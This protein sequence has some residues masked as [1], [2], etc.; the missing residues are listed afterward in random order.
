MIK[1]KHNHIIWSARQK[2]LLSLHTGYLPETTNGLL[3]FLKPNSHIPVWSPTLFRFSD[4]GWT[5][6][7]LHTTL[8]IQWTSRTNGGGPHRKRSWMC[9]NVSN[10][11]ESLGMMP[12]LCNIGVVPGMSGVTPV[13]LVSSAINCINLAGTSVHQ[14]S[15]SKDRNHSG[16]HQDRPG[17]HLEESG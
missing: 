3:F 13:H 6:L 16:W 5:V 4:L 12:E 14:G 8:V 7:D 2:T 17:L 15:C 11:W 9:E 10:H 1:V